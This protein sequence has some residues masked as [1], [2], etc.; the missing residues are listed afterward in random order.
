MEKPQVPDIE[1]TS[2]KPRKARFFLFSNTPYAFLLHIA[3]AVGLGFGLVW[4]LFN[5]YLP[6]LTNHGETITVPLL[7]EMPL[8]E[9]EKLLATKNLRYEVIDSSFQVNAVPGTVIDQDPPMNTK[10]KLNRK[11]YL[12]VSSY[13]PPKIAIPDIVDSSV[14]NA[15]LLLKSHELK[16]GSIEYVDDLA[17]NAVLGIML[18]SVEYSKEDLR[19]GIIVP[20]GTRIDL[21]VG[22][23][24]GNT[25]MEVPNVLGM[26]YEEAQTLLRGVGLSVGTIEFVSATTRPPG[27]VVKQEPAPSRTNKIKIGEIVDLWVAFPQDYDAADTTTRSTF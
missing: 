3:V 21:I 5:Q 20:K 19:R 12:T 18:D 8:A 14:K 24:L 23:G 17:T 6:S 13:L 16:I 1:Q 11:M 4:V 9:V 22:N 15:Q 26:D 27:A 10:V 7:R 25:T 2:E